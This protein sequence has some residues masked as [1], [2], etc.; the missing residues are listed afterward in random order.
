ML[1]SVY[2]AAPLM[3]KSGVVRSSPMPLTAV[4]QRPS[5]LARPR[6]V[7][8]QLSLFGPPGAVRR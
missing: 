3:T 8:Q 1:T 4:A 7:P 5:V 6:Q 2:S